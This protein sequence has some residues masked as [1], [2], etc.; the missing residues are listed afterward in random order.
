MKKSLKSIVSKLSLT[1]LTLIFMQ[2]ISFASEKVPEI[3]ISE[4]SVSDLSGSQLL[5]T[6]WFWVLIIVV[7]SVFITAFFYARI[8]EETDDSHAL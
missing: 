5:N 2:S 3:Y 6:T 8:T 1:A 7:A 4:S